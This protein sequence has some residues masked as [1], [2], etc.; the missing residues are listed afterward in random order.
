[1]RRTVRDICADMSTARDTS[2]Y[3][4]VILGAGASGLVCAMTASARGRSVLVIDHGA[5]PG[6]KLSITGGG[7]CNLSNRSI[8]PGDY[9]GENPDF[10][11][12]ALSRFSVKDMLDLAASAGIPLEEREHGQLFCIRSAKDVVNF[13]VAQC[14]KNGCALALEEKILGVERTTADEEPPLF[15]VRTSLGAYRSEKVV[16]ATGGPAWPQV[17]ATGTGY[18]IARSFGHAIVSIRPALCGFVMERNWPLSALSG[19]SVPAGIRVIHPARAQSARGV[20]KNAPEQ[21]AAA[22]ALPLLFTHKGLSGPAAL[23]ASLYW[24]KGAVLRVDFL[25]CVRTD[26]LFDAPGAGKLLC[27]TILKKHLPDRLCDALLPEASGAKKTAELSRRERTDIGAMVHAHDL[28][29]VGTEDFSRAEVTAG[30]VSTRDVSS[31]NM[32][33]NRQTGL[34]FCG[35]VLDVTGRLGGYNLHWAFASGMAAGNSI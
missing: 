30:G 7:K 13:L 32:E 8:I 35:E 31:R 18:E 34:Y 24:R 9:S 21:I 27:R 4:A 23:Q 28:I 22:E 1:M 3:D 14:R 12:S 29:P 16:V 19:I 33:S 2:I 6:R 10:C 15:T 11:R 5:K 20:M 17:G 26:A 25:P